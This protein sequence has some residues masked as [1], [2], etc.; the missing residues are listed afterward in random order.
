M[1]WDKS[2]DV[3]VIG[4]GG[5]ALFGALVAATRGLRTCLVEKTEYFGGTSAYSGGSIWMPGNHVLARDGVNDSVQDGL[6]YFRS[7]VGD[8]TAESVQRAFIGT[9]PEVTDFLENVAGIPLGFRAFPDYFAAPGRSANGRSIFADD[10]AA[11]E[12]GAR[13]D[14]IRPVVA[15][16]QF[17]HEVDRSVFAGG[18]ALI[19]RLVKALDEN[20]NATLML[21]TRALSLITDAGV[22]AGVVIDGPE[23]EQ[24]LGARAGV[25]VAAGGFEA[26]P[27]LRREW[28]QM[29][30]A[31][32]TSSSPDTGTGDAVRMLAEAGAELDLLDQCWWAPA[33]LF[34]N[35][36][37]VFTLGIRSGIIID[38][39]A[40]RFANELLPYDQMGRAMRAVMSQD[41]ESAF[42]FI[43]DDS[44]GGA[45]PA[46]AAPM[47]DRNAMV[48]AGLWFTATDVE[49]LAEQIGVDGQALA[50]TVDRFNGFAEAGHDDDFDR[51]ADPYGR[52]FIGATSTAEA[53]R[54]IRTTALN[55]VRLV[56]GDLG[57]KGGAVIDPDGAVIGVSGHV[58]P[59]LFAAG[60]SSASVSG[61]AYPGPGTPLGSGM[62]MAYRAV[63]AMLTHLA[64]DGQS[65]GAAG[66]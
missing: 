24:R 41:K 50:A 43:F 33:T 57:T 15:A 61:T 49:E 12:L 13:A 30:T 4:S 51:G 32:W 3:V 55:A 63:G 48:K 47:P 23:G 46:I 9:G 37:A 10:I 65:A 16:D 2:Y 35:G 66:S 62:V 11:T 25:L 42:W 5:A 7:V 52:F 26:D 60:N 19:A 45:M 14:D 58:I 34:P 22:V 21:R 29:P 53:L 6:T 44:E 40:Q 59:G 27:A 28:Q 31:D 18:Q 8:R 56:P 39:S 17:G 38:D 36:R 64:A 1:T 20:D 54:P